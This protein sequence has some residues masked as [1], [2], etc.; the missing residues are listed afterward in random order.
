MLTKQCIKCEKRKPFADF[1]VSKANTDGRDNSCKECV[2]AHKRKRYAEDPAVRKYYRE[3]SV[4]WHKDNR[5][6][7][8]QKRKA[9][10]DEDADYREQVKKNNL[11]RYYRNKKNA[12]A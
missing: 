5:E 10:Y 7:V 8:L 1:Y 9:R 6:E 11:A 2:K 4:E 12:N 3:K